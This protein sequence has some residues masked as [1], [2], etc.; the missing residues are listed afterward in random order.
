MFLSL[1]CLTWCQMLPGLFA[2]EDMV[3]GTFI[4]EY[5]GEIIDNQTRLERR[6]DIV[7]GKHMF[8]AY[9]N[10]HTYLDSTYKASIARSAYAARSLCGCA[11]LQCW[12]YISDS[13]IIH[14]IPTADL[15]P[16]L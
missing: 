2:R 15:K 14:V 5:V 16:G 12:L 7:A 13:S 6:R 9:L 8:V 11:T 3:P 4:R 10:K 1:A